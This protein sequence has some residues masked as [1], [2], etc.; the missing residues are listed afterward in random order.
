LVVSSA[1][2][3]RFIPSQSG[4]SSFGPKWN[5]E[6]SEYDYTFNLTKDLKVLSGAIVL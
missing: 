6:K 2:P 5:E 1:A 3:R 4:W